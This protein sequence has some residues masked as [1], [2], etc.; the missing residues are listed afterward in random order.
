MV[1]LVKACAGA[2]ARADNCTAL[3]D[4]NED[5]L[6]RAT[7]ENVAANARLYSCANAC[8]QRCR[9]IS[10]DFESACMLLEQ[11]DGPACFDVILT[12]ESIYNVMSAKQ[13]LAGCARC[14]S[15]DGRVLVASKSHYFGVGGGLSQFKTLVQEQAL[16]SCA[17][18]NRVDDGA[19]NVREVL[20]LARMQST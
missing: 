18:I 13:I 15:V 10:G 11:Q 9:Y 1:A 6:R 5:V 14:L 3:Q 7:A 4:F 19:S 12:A 8:T 2:C 20:E 16:F 17:V